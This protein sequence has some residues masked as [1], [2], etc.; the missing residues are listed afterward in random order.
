MFGTPDIAFYFWVELVAGRV[1]GYDASA[2]RSRI[3]PSTFSMRFR[4]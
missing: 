3:P 4:L 1:R 2:T